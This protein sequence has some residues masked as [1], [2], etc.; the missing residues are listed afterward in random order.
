MPKSRINTPKTR[1]PIKRQRLGGLTVTIQNSNRKNYDYVVVIRRDGQRIR[2]R[3]FKSRK[4]AEGLAQMW[5]IEAGNSGA[6][7][8]S[9]ITDS[10]KRA[11]ME[12]RA[13]LAPFGKTPSDAIEFYL[14]HLERCRVSIT[15]SELLERVMTAKHREKKSQRYLAD[16]KGRLGRFTQ[17]FGNRT[18]AD[19][20]GDEIGTWLHRLEGSPVTLNNY[21]RLVGVLFSFAVKIGACERNPV[22]SIDP[23]KEPEGEVGILTVKQAKDLLAAALETPEILPA[24]ALGL[25]AG[26]RDAELRQMDWCEINLQSGMIEIKASKA[27]SARRRLITIQPALHSW[28]APHQQSTGTIWPLGDRGRVLHEAARRKAGFGNLGDETPE[29]RASGL[30]LTP[31][32]HNALRHSFASY[33]LAHF[34]NSDELALELGHTNTALIFQ[35]YRE[36]VQPKEAAQFWGL[37]HL[38]KQSATQT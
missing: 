5:S 37:H 1:R 23:I 21:R 34:K 4:A 32:P 24:I 30:A 31:W 12:W 17:E 33:H 28:L 19:V 2:E 13:T 14:S 25:F 29:E 27:K 3:Y 35:H 6:I 18:A 26:V 7:A 36:L 15:V 8:A 20:R 38:P 22:Q 11:L 16:L 9:S 10:D